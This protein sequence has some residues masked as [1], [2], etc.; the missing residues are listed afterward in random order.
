MHQRVLS[1]RLAGS[2]Y[3]AD[4]VPCSCQH[5]FIST[6]KCNERWSL[7]APASFPRQSLMKRWGNGDHSRTYLTSN[8]PTLLATKDHHNLPL[9]HP[10]PF[11]RILHSALSVIDSVSKLI[12]SLASFTAERPLYHYAVFV[13]HVAIAF[14]HMKLASG[15]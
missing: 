10:F 13:C 8:D 5:L 6:G 1:Q 7:H 11:K 3:P 12:L 15:A 9:K 4:I 2:L 14:L